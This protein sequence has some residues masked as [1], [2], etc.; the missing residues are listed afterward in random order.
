M[1][2]KNL[3]TFL[4]VAELNSFTRAGQKLGF[5]QSTV[6]FQI[7]QLER[8]LGTQL[9]ERINHTV[10]LTEKGRDVLKFAHQISKMTQELD[11]R[12][13]NE[14]EV[15]GNVR[16][17][18]ADSLCDNM[19]QEGFGEFRDRYP[20]ISLKIITAGTEEMFRLLNQNEADAVLTLDNHIF[21]AEYVIAREERA[22]VHFVADSENPLCER[23]ELFPEDL[24]GQPFLLTEKG[25]SY[26]RL[27]DE[28]FAE[29]SME[30]LPVLEIGSAGLI[31]S[32]VEQGAGISFL[33]DYVTEEKVRAGRLRYLPVKNF[34]IEIWKQLLYHR[35][36][37]V[38]PQLESALAYLSEREFR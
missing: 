35:D 4:H 12:L 14:E 32:L 30:I 23:E 17:A 11:K 25:M 21:H 20:G 29:L 2:L 16:I 27:M 22:G 13:Q 7:K 15:S 36:K 1:D 3:L 33:P 26:R 28:K 24:A 19:L 37:W 34:E 31:C 18:M 5:S 8:E 9:F 6:S 10:V 38:T